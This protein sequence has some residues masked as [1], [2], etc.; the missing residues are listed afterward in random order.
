MN[1]LGYKCIFIYLYKKMNSL[2]KLS[3]AELKALKR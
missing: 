2:S 3:Y 1:K